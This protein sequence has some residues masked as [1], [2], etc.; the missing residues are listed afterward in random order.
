[1]TPTTAAAMGAVQR[2]KAGV[3]SAVLN[4]A[5]QVGGS[6]GI[7]ITGAIVASG[8]SSGLAAGDSRPDAFVNGLHNGLLVAAAIALVGSLVGFATVRKQPHHF[9]SDAAPADRA[10]EAVPAELVEY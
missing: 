10:D 8:I 3:G 4:S 1:M 9:E 7:A 2:D 6:L 5:R